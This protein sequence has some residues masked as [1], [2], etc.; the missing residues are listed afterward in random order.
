[1]FQPGKTRRGGTIS[2]WSAR[3]PNVTGADTFFGHT[4]RGLT[5]IAEPEVHRMIRVALKHDDAAPR[6]LSEDEF[7]REISRLEATGFAGAVSGPVSVEA[8]DGDGRVRWRAY[9]PSVQ[10]LAPLARELVRESSAMS[11]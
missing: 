5:P 3:P 11:G 10:R 2:T 4:S 8:L 9:F 6:V 1:M 7:I